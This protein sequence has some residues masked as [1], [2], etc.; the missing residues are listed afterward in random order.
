MGCNCGH[1][2]SMHRQALPAAD[3]A[4]P[5]RES[6]AKQHAIQSASGPPSCP[7]SR[8][9]CSAVW[10]THRPH[11]ESHIAVVQEQLL[12][13][14]AQLLV[15]A[16]E[17]QGRL[18]A[19]QLQHFQLGRTDLLHRGLKVWGRGR[20]LQ[21]SRRLHERAEASGG[22]R[23]A[24]AAGWREVRSGAQ[25]PRCNVTCQMLHAASTA[26]RLKPLRPLRAPA[27]GGG[28][29]ASPATAPHLF[30]CAAKG[31]SW[32]WKWRWRQGHA[33]GNAN[34]A[35]LQ[36][37][38]SRAGERSVFIASDLNTPTATQRAVTRCTVSDGHLPALCVAAPALTARNAIR[39]TNRSAI[40]PRHVAAECPA[41]AAAAC[42]RRPS[43][44]RALLTPP[45]Q[46]CWL[47][48]GRCAH[49]R[50]RNF[51]G[52]WCLAAGVWGAATRG[53]AISLRW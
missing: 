15:G 12:E 49:R 38:A 26:R 41:A 50:S 33:W 18:H 28:V 1:R 46:H 17:G 31:R 11:L 40:R 53:P 25:G 43:L 45:V 29:S 14:Q 37:Q 34:R 36:G 52:R 13:A 48:K 44:T 3:T 27:S 39:E 5:D 21:Q 51:R 7:T 22:A 30:R 32:C 8:P 42:R 10:T 16:A 2:S 35:G 20:G 19:R 23:T 47:V 6:P 4:A 9:T 24:A